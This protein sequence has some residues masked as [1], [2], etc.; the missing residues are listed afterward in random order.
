M[1]TA[2]P[3]PV[4]ID[5]MSKSG[6]DQKVTTTS[7][8]S[9]TKQRVNLGAAELNRLAMMRYRR[10]NWLLGLGLLT[11]VMSI[12]GYS[13]FAVRQESLDLDELDEPV[14]DSSIV[15]K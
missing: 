13:I 9:A 15:S 14:D 8:S 7:T 4:R 1:L 3:I 10:R 11:G 6:T 2:F 5:G 12:F